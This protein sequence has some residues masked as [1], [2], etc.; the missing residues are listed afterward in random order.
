MLKI[1]FLVSSGGGNA[2]FIYLAKELSI[3]KN[4]EIFIVADRE[5]SAIDFA[6]SS[7]IYSK[8]INYRRDSNGELISIL[9][10]LNPDIIIT[11]WAKIIDEDIV[12]R[13]KGKMINLHYSLLP[14]FKGEMGSEPIKN[15]YKQNCQ[16][17]GVTCHYVEKDV[18]A[19]K[20]ISQS[21]LKSNIPIEN[22]IQE[23]FRRGCLILLNSIIILSQKE[24]I[25]YK[26][27][28]HFEYSPALKFNKNRFNEKFWDR[29]SVL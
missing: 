11:T 12:N 15:A 3:L 13:Y 16:Y 24:I 26:E 21:I 28:D 9:E 10:S 27:N 5:C 14:A 25:E 4:I 29:V 19:G 17:I 6:K 23:V 18:D 22:T 7:N 8:V 20:I 2:K 1:C